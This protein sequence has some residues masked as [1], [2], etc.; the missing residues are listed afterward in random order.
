M[1]NNHLF[2]LCSVLILFLV[3]TGCIKADPTSEAPEITLP[4]KESG[5][6]RAVIDGVLQSGEWEQISP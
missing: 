2:C 4:S 1:P 5:N 6:D 3:L